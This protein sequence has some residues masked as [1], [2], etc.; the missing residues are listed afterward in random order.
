MSRKLAKPAGEMMFQALYF[1]PQA[2]C[3]IP[4][5]TMLYRTSHFDACD[6]RDLSHSISEY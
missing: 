3:H 5:L 4:I 2:V 1:V 6:A